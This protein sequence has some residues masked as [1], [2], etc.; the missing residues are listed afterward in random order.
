MAGNNSYSLYHFPYSSGL[1]GGQGVSPHHIFGLFPLLTSRDL[2]R[3]LKVRDS[4]LIVPPFQMEKYGQV[5]VNPQEM[6]IDF[7]K[8]AVGFY[9]IIVVH[10]FQ[11]EDRNPNLRECPVGIFFARHVGGRR[12][13]P[14][15]H[16][17]E[18]RTIEIIADINTKTGELFYP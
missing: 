12:E 16:P 14:E 18:C 6:V 13:E 17:I 5:Y 3:L 10:N 7:R 2:G 8:L 11:V 15:T 1:F 9:S 4:R